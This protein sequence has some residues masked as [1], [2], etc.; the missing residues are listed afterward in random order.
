MSTGNICY[1]SLPSASSLKRHQRVDHKN[2]KTK[3]FSCKFC[4]ETFC[5]DYRL[6]KHLLQV[7]KNGLQ[8]KRTCQ[9]CNLDFVLF[10]DF[11]KHIESHPDDLICV[12]CGL[13][14]QDKV[15][16][17]L[18]QRSHKAVNKEFQKF[19]CDHCPA[20][21]ISRNPLMVSVNLIEYFIICRLKH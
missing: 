21:F 16:F 7:H 5:K 8:A 14:F 17:G 12:I 1:K 4:K 20:G 9:P 10:D 11:K 2:S 6:Q 3:T 18:H 15:S 13:G 19:F